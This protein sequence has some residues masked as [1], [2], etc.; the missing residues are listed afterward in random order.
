MNVFITVSLSHSNINERGQHKNGSVSYSD[1]IAH[2]RTFDTG[3][4]SADS[5]CYHHYY[6]GFPAYVISINIYSLVM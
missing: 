1:T 4:I 5:T 6:E 3:R 2:C